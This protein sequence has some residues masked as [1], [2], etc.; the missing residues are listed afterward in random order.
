DSNNHRIRRVSPSGTITTV[1]G[2][3]QVGF[4]GDG[5][6]ATAADLGLPVDV[7]ATRDGGFLI[8]DYGNNRIRRVLP[9]GTITT[10]AGTGAEGFSGDG[11]PAPAAPMVCAHGS[12]ATP[13]GGFWIAAYEYT[14][15]RRVSPT[16]TITTVAGSGGLGQGGFS[17]D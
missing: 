10:V 4:S 3:G 8:A 11:G 7:A 16:G 6:R 17:G 14:R 13:D 5:G 12:S 1:A 15:V 9:N 2:T